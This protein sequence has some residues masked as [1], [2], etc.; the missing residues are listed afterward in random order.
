MAV[1]AIFEK[2]FGLKIN[3]KKQDQSINPNRPYE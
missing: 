3:K 2:E 1:K